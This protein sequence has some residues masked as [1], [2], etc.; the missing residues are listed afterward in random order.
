LT[1]ARH[2]WVLTV[3]RKIITALRHAGCGKSG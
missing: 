3:H 2:V 1:D